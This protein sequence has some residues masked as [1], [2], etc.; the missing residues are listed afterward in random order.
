MKACYTLLFT[1]MAFMALA[2]EKPNIILIY[3]DDLGYG[4]IG[5]NGAVGVKTPFID[6]LAKEGINFTDAHAPASTCTPS[7]YALLTGQYAF[8]R[9]AAILPGD[10]P[11]LIDTAAVTLPKVLKQAG[12]S[13]GVVGKW[14]L[15]LGN[16]QIDWN[17]RVSPGPKEVGFDYS[18]LIPA[19]GDRV[20]TV[21]LENQ[22]VKGLETSDPITVSYGKP[23][24]DVPTGVNSPHLLKQHTDPYHRGVVIN[25]I[26]RIGYM[27]GGKNAEWIDEDFPF[28]L[29]EKAGDFMEKQEDN[30]FFLFFSLHDIHQ[31]RVPH[32]N[33]V[34][35]SSMGPRGDV[36]AQL[37]WTVGQIVKKL[38][39]LNIREE[40]LIIFTSDNGPVLD[41]GYV[42]YARELV[43]KH[44][45]G[46]IYR[47]AKY[48]A[49]ESGTR[50]PTIVNWP[51]KVTPQVSD[52]LVGQVD[53][54]ASIA[55]LVGV[56]IQSKLDSK[57][58]L[59]TWLGKSATGREYLLE[60]SYVMGLRWKNWKY[61]QPTDNSQPGWITQKY[62]DAGYR[63]APQ[64]FDLSSDPSE[65][66]NLATERPDIVKKLE[67]A[68][69]KTLAKQ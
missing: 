1:L 7:R 21:Y 34:E 24:P 18:F 49:Y 56:P 36:I 53:L 8:R 68:L 5:V 42:D 19:T 54:L 29:T 41:D 37:D 9:K 59:H 62:I 20:P 50:I 17:K 22:E 43:G 35:S 28:V 12:Y 15:G 11:L 57:N 47:G 10:A 69:Q 55:E 44:Q 52:A 25:G 14:H 3:A 23:L 66:K 39:S 65:Q 31:P 4:D 27:S 64:L 48:S 51:G 13:T 63:K 45:P 67:E 58:Q 16:G 2:Q 26:S 61:I 46:G 33:F 30:P 38:D 6:S 60:E 40:T 32:V